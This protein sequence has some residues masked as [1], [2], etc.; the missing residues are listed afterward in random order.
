MKAA[1]FFSS[2]ELVIQVPLEKIGPIWLG[3]SYKIDG[4]R[5][6]RRL[7]SRLF[8]LVFQD[9]QLLLKSSGGCVMMMLVSLHFVVAVRSEQP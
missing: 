1:L 8:D 6:S 7:N 5:G 2:L 4:E 9:A 3:R